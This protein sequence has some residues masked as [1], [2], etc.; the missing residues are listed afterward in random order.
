MRTV[1]LKLFMV[2]S[3]FFPAFWSTFNED[4]KMEYYAVFTAAYAVLLIYMLLQLWKGKRK[5]GQRFVLV[6]LALLVLYNGLSLYMNLNYLHWYGEQ[7]NNTIALLFFLVL[8]AYDDSL[9]EKEDDCIRFF[10]GCAVLS[11]VLSIVYYFMGYTAFLICN[12][13]FYFVRLPDDY[14]EFRHYWIYSH[15]S[16]Y[17]LML[18]AFMAVCIRFRDRFKHRVSWFLSMGVFLTALFLTHSWTGFGAAA[19]IFVGAVLD[20]IDWKKFRFRKIYLLWAGLLAVASG[21]AGKLVLAERDILSLGGRRA[22]W[23]GALKAIRE[24]PNGWGY[25]F[26]EA[27][28]DATPTWSVNN[29]HNVFLNAMLRFSVPVGLCFIGM[30][31]LI[32]VFSLVRSRSFLAAG[33]WIGFFILLNM[34]YCLLNYELG[35]FLFV[36]Y[37]VCIYRPKGKEEVENGVFE[38][39][40]N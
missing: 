24:M 18:V 35:M 22:I 31:L 28:F 29:A 13:R 25:L 17:A 20:R 34:D 39:K 33:M 30:I 6:F 10:L 1:C 4:Y 5:K 36:I 11:N 15:K 21:I 8:L 14:Y 27:L 9:G 2:F 7:I 16:D 12:N 23:S 26:G 19:L 3:L 38:A 32:A 37:L 40:G